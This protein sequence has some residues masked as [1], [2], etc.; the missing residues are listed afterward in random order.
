MQKSKRISTLSI[1]LLSLLSL[2]TSLFNPIAASALET[3]TERRPEGIDGDNTWEGAS[4]ADG[5][6][7]IAINTAGELFI[8]TDSGVS[9]NPTNPVLDSENW[10]TVASDADGSNLIVA[11][12]GRAYITTNGGSSWA[13]TQPAGDTDKLWITVGSDADGSTLMAAASFGRLYIS[14]N[15][16]TTWTERQPA[17]DVN[18]S[19][20]SMVSDTT[21]TNLFV[22]CA[23]RLYTSTDGGVNWTERQPMGNTNFFARDLASDATGLKLVAGVEGGRLYTSA[24]GGATWTERQPAGDTNQQWVGLDSGA[25]GTHLI[26][27]AN[28]GRLYTSSDSG[29]TWTERRPAG[30]VDIGWR[31]AAMGGNFTFFVGANNGRLYTGIIDEAGP[32]I[33]TYS[34]ADNATD[35]AVTANLTITLDSTFVTGTNKNIIIKKSSDDSIVETI[36]VSSSQVIASGLEITIN[37]SASLSYSTS[38]YVQMDA[39]A[40]QD[41]YSNDMLAISNTTTWNFTTV[42]APR[43]GGGGYSPP[44]VSTPVA[45][46]ITMPIYEPPLI[47]NPADPVTIS[48]INIAPPI[49]VQPVIAPVAPVITPVVVVPEV[50]TP[51]VV[52][53]VSAPLITAPPI[54][55]KLLNPGIR[56]VEVLN[57]QKT[58]NQL[59]YTV[60][61]T[62][63]GSIGNETNFFGKAT[64]N[65]LLNFQ[66]LN[67][68]PTTGIADK[69]TIETINQKS[70]T[71]E[72]LGVK[73]IKFT[74]NLATG[75]NGDDVKRLQQWLNANGFTVAESGPGSVGKETKQF[76]KATREA[77]KRF[78]KDSGEKETGIFSVNTKEKINGML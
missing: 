27:A 21:G 4:D 56:S 53:P 30:D 55:V 72:V 8:S 33:T 9:W 69:A 26:A 22:Q 7:L 38:Y 44:L 67:N 2:A 49:I 58:L 37:P 13:E 77:L 48:P 20:Q 31:F 35:V 70:V 45:P 6:N 64:Y 59:G 74:R 32:I 18:S 51:V 66:K 19:C 71:G 39:G 34:P 10:S 73:L 23:N 68:L 5:S 36:S 57:L 75:S 43:V 62:G 29:V 16:G 54:Q 41:A 46:V 60:A 3:W 12:N 76:G 17:G 63:P 24:D 47:P 15:G 25:D 42:A 50:T 78:Q 65:A 40:F 14:A 28:S 52:T 1:A 61:Q 11:R